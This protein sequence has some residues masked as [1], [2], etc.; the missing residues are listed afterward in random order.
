VCLL[1]NLLLFL[2]LVLPLRRL[3]LPWL[4][5]H[6]TLAVALTTAA[7]H[8]LILFTHTDCSGDCTVLLGFREQ[9]NITNGG[10]AYT[11]SVAPITN[12]PPNLGY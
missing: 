2:G 5:A 10:Y 1:T 8:Y 11:Q 4:A 12:S 7:T 3:L 9:T 6:S